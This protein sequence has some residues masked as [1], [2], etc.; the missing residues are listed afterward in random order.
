MR[1]SSLAH[2]A[3]AKVPIVVSGRGFFMIFGGSMVGC[4]S[5]RRAVMI[6][7]ILISLTESMS[8]YSAMLSGSL[9]LSS[10]VLS[11]FARF[12]RRISISSV[13]QSGERYFAHL[14]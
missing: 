12:L 14:Y 3:I 9:N 2:C 11:L 5:H 6:P 7:N 10:V 1:K 13:P 4:T 8:T